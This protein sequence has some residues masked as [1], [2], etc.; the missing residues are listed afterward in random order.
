PRWPRAQGDPHHAVGIARRARLVRGGLVVRRLAFAVPGDLATPT[1]GYAY[2]RRVIAELGPLGW[3]VEL[4]DLGE[5]FPRPS[6]EQIKTAQT[7]LMAIP[8]GCPVVVDGLALG[9]L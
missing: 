7:R 9:G 6:N 2:D 1:G 5:G 3:S 8:A 4:V